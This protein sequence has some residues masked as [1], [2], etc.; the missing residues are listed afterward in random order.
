[1]DEID[2][3]ND[4]MMQDLE[5]RIAA[6]RLQPVEPGPEECDECGEPMPKLR[7]QMGCRLCVECKSRQERIASRF[8]R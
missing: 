7:Q 4:R 8:A 3:A 5:Q 6:A 1:M 2:I